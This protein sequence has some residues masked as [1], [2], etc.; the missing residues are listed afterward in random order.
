MRTATALVPTRIGGPLL[1]A[2]SMPPALAWLLMPANSLVGTA[3]AWIGWQ[4]R[5]RAA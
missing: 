1:V 5:S 3:L 2:Y 4:I